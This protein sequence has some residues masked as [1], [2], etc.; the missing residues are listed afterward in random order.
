L[1]AA[2]EE[3]ARFGYH[4][5]SMR[6]IAVAAECSEPLIY[7]M[8]ADK[9][10]LFAALLDHVS[11]QIETAIDGVLTA[12]GDPLTNWVNFLE[13]GMASE[14]YARMIRFRM[15]AIT[16]DEPAIKEALALGAGRLHSRVATALET[17][18]EM[19]SVRPDVDSEY[20]TWMWLGITLAASFREGIGATDGFSGMKQHA[21]TFLEGL[22]P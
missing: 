11:H 3:F 17:A 15:L 9:Q 13:V 20:V 16:V 14:H 21:I 18:K 22:R 2:H 4:G 7:K 10:R 5:A 1:E 8:F 19:K 12:P 6:R